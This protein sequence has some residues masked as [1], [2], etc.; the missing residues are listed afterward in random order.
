M[1]TEA[2]TI[3]F[4]LSLTVSGSGGSGAITC[5]LI[6]LEA[7][8]EAGLYG[9]MSRSLGPQIRGGESAAML[10]FASE[11]V[12]CLDDRFDLLLG[13]D[14]LNVERFADEIPLDAQSLIISDATSH[15]VPECLLASGARVLTLPITELAAG[16]A[17]GRGNM[18]ALGILGRLGG[19]G[20]AALTRASRRVLA[21]KGEGVTAAAASCVEAGYAAVAD[22]PPLLRSPVLPKRPRWNISGN[23]ACGLGGLRAGVRFAAAYPITPASDMLEW[24]APRLEQLGGS[25][26]QAEDELASVNML[27]GA[28]YGGVPALTATSGPGLSLM[29]E[30]LGLA[31][32]S[33]IPLVV[34]NVTRVGPSTGIPTKSEQ[35]DLNL[36]LYGQHGD[37]PHLVLAP[38]GIGDCALTTEWAVGLAERLQTPAI[39][40]SDQFLGQNRAVIPP[41]VAGEFGLQRRGARGCDEPYRRYRLTPDGVSCMGSP[42]QTGCLYTSEGLEHDQR[43]DPSSLAFD[44]RAQSD[45]R[46]HKLE[47]FDYGPTWVETEGEGE[48]C[49]LTWGSC[50]GVV[51]EAARRLRSRGM[52]VRVIA[53]RLLAPLQHRALKERLRGAARILVVEQNHSA[54]FFHYLHARQVLPDLAESLAR[55]GPIPWRPG[56][57]LAHCL[58][59]PAS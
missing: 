38:L 56:E 2:T 54:Q 35:S 13:L 29:A 6:L 42:G 25:L 30:G 37:A 51:F 39:V 22:R 15:S 36:A 27:I 34:V 23:E 28:S 47:S 14:W 32:A 18:V 46:R 49:L 20:L 24:L 1:Q 50:A 3:D 31:V 8:A 17:G 48:V 59:E 16:I 33:E 55:P 21:D 19:L 57:I 7:I 5:G 53:L 11:P 12:D 52:G 45:K 4:D 26:L 9:L 43:G 10:R 41:A 44:H 58:E 40:L